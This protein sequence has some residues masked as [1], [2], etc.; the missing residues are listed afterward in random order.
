[1]SEQLYFFRQTK[2]EEIY[3]QQILAKRTSNFVLQE[4]EKP[5]DKEILRYKKMLTS[6]LNPSKI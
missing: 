5:S 4:E 1:M 6:K 2:F 3:Y